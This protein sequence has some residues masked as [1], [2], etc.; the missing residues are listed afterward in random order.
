M[1][2]DELV[3]GAR[4]D[5][6][7]A[8]SADGRQVLDEVVAT[9]RRDGAPGRTGRDR[10]PRPVLRWSLLGTGLVGAAAAAAL[11]VP[12]IVAA[13]E[14][15]AQGPPVAGA[16]PGTTDGGTTA[17]TARDILLAAATRAERAPAETGRYW[18]VRTL[19]VFGAVRLGTGADGYWMVRR[20]VEESW[21]AGAAKDPSW[22]GRRDI[23]VR[24]RTE[25]DA[26]A[27]R[28][29]G[30]P[31]EW[32]LDA[33]G[34]RDI[35]LSTRPG[36]GELNKETQPPTYLEDLGQ[37]SLAQVRQLPADQRAL[38]DWVTKRVRTRMGF[39]PGSAQSNRLVFGF[40]G[41]MLLDTPAGPGVRAA[42]FRI[43]ADIPGVRGLGPVRDDSGRP[44]QGVEFRSGAQ[45]D[46][47]IIDPAT[48]LLLAGGYTSGP[49][50]KSVP[51]KQSSTLV[52]S[53]EWS[54]AK[55]RVP[56]VP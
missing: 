4:P 9:T 34:A 44:G 40:L 24:P 27:W 20:T 38:R 43:L 1:N 5:A 35:E 45:T 47:L 11:V 53:A 55:P 54:D 42:A 19:N 48:H 50:G 3:R 51:A 7:W 26:R 30:S 49:G 29:A 39:A 2:I 52:L 41:R 28:A 16:L 12:A 14:P 46:L 15:P 23:G 17:L 10:A 13:P 31:T 37:L 33:D 18:H 36:A 21:D 8:R 25:A 32:T 22:H 6:G 56:S